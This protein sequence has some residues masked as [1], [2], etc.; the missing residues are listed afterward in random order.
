MDEILKDFPTAKE[1]F[2][3]TRDANEIAKEIFLTSV[4]KYILLESEM[5]EKKYSFLCSEK[6]REWL[7][8]FSN[9]GYTVRDIIPKL[10]NGVCSVVSISWGQEIE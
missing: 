1:M 6:E 8:Y 4:K 9:L 10:N 2:A 7:I 3:R 5:G